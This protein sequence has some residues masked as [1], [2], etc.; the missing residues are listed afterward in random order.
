MVECARL[1]SEYTERYRRFESS[2]L[3]ILSKFQFWEEVASALRASAGARSA[4]K[5]D[6]ARI[7][8]A[9]RGVNESARF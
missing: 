1:E 4:P 3:R 6:S 7:R 2:C 5:V 8:H 9:P